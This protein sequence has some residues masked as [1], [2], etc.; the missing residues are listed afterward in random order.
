MD[1]GV[2]FT[3]SKLYKCKSC[4]AIKFKTCLYSKGH[5][6][7]TIREKVSFNPIFL[8]IFI[9]YNGLKGYISWIDYK[10]YNIKIKLIKS[11]DEAVDYVI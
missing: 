8:I 9:S 6:A 3:D 4:A 2:E 5:P 1:T 7:N 11:K 10:S